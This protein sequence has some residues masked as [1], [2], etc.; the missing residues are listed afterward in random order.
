MSFYSKESQKLFDDISSGFNEKIDRDHMEKEKCFDEKCSDKKFKSLTVRT[1]QQG[2]WTP[3]D[4]QPSFLTYGAAYPIPMTDG[5]IAVRDDF[6]N[7]ITFE[8]NSTPNIHMLTPDDF[9][10]YKKGTWSEIAPLPIVNGVQY[11]PD[12]YAQ[13]ILPDGRWIM[14]GGENNGPDFVFFGAGAIY[15]PVTNIWTPVPAPP[16]FIDLY[17]G[18]RAPDFD[19]TGDAASV[20][21]ENGTF[22]LQNAS[23][24]QSALLD[25]KNL[26]WK[27]TGLDKAGNQT[28]IDPMDEEGWTLLPNG[29]VLTV[30]CNTWFFLPGYPFPPDIKFPSSYTQ[31]EIYNP[32]KETWSNKS[33]STIVPLDDSNPSAPFNPDVGITSEIGPAVLRPDG[34]VIQFGGTKYNAFYDYKENK[35]IPTTNYPSV[36][37]I[38]QT[39]EDA[40]ASLLQ[41]GNVLVCTG[42]GFTGIPSGVNFWE[43]TLE[44]NQFVPVPNVP[45]GN[46]LF[47]TQC[48]LL[49]LPSGQVMLTA[50]QNNS[51]GKLIFLYTPAKKSY[52]ACWAP[53]IKCAPVNVRRGRTYDISGIRFN[54]MSQCNA[55]GDDYQAAT[56]WPFV[57]ITNNK[58]NHVKY[59]R[60]HDFSFMGVA[61]DKLVH[62]KFDVPTDIDLGNSI[63]EVVVNGIASLPFYLRVKNIKG[64]DSCIQKNILS[65]TIASSIKQDPKIQNNVQYINPKRL[66]R[67]NLMK[68]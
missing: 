61:S 58:T 7:P 44:D 6:F 25:A 15:D 60:T 54:G 59:C 68:K 16:F 33:G 3:L 11:S 65:N 39:C 21:L 38:Q 50:K 32:C 51:N 66:Y 13:A 31:S 19:T 35:W 14:M 30:D 26:T 42:A 52:N 1:T 22:M 23:S 64:N 43:F 28:K 5:R 49:M 47:S 41:T 55:F 62:A 12:A 24:Y 37:G 63:L 18:T 53:V 17:G 40:P 27:E 56:N 9:G 36:N 57:R 8:G 34:L 45:T 20:V 29:K 10:N 48:C 67:R 4:N 46:D 2:I